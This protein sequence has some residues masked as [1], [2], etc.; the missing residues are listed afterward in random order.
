MAGTVLG[1]EETDKELVLA[2]INHVSISRIHGPDPE[3]WKGEKVKFYPTTC[4]AFGDPNTPCI[5][6]RSLDPKT[7]KPPDI[8]I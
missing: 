4:R 7:N 5:R 3:K 1:F 8:G 2:K 6:V